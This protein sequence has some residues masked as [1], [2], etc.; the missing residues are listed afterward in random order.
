MK[1]KNE[2]ERQEEGI[3]TILLSPHSLQLLRHR[4]IC[5]HQRRAIQSYHFTI[6]K[7]YQGKLP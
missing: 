4:Q 5:R 6:A 7:K 3:G 1:N 2:K